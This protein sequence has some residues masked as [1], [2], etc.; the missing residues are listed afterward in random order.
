MEETGQDLGEINLKSLSLEKVFKL[1]L[2]NYEEKVM[3]IC[4]EAKEEAKNEEN[5]QKIHQA[6]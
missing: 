1:E 6:W 5:L 3:E 4:I 2:Q